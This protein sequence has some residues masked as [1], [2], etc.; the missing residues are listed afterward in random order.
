[1][2]RKSHDRLASALQVDPLHLVE[3]HIYHRPDEPGVLSRPTNPAFT[4]GWEHELEFIAANELYLRRMVKGLADEL[5]RDELLVVAMHAMR[6]HDERRQKTAKRGRPP[7]A[8]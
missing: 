2:N 1:M 6:L 7:K 5:T 3:I 8:K 4:E